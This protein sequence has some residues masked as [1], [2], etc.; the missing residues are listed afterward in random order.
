[1]KFHQMTAA[2]LSYEYEQFCTG[3]NSKDRHLPMAIS[4]AYD[5]SL[6]V[7]L[8]SLES[9]Y[10]VVFPVQYESGSLMHYT[11][12]FMTYMWEDNGYTRK[13][14]QVCGDW[15]KR[16][17]VPVEGPIVFKLHGSPA[18]KLPAQIVHDDKVSKNLR[19]FMI[20][21]ESDHLKASIFSEGADFQLP[22]WIIGEL[23]EKS[24]SWWFLGYRLDDWFSRLRIL[25]SLFKVS[26]PPT[27][28]ALGMNYDL[29]RSFV[30]EKFNVIR[31]SV[32]LAQVEHILEQIPEVQEIIERKVSEHD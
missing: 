24:S 28:N 3:D 20:I 7:A 32:D 13:E 16:S 25:S 10:H 21:S 6:E 26:P 14:P 30:L 29:Y 18:E 2:A 9:N 15:E 31:S 4:T 27:S 8:R 11:W 19:H 17:N 12:L 5:R 23:K 22:P 1:M